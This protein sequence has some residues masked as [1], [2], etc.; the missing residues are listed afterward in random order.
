MGFVVDINCDMGESFGIYRIGNDEEVIKHITSSNIACGFHASD[1]VIMEKTVKL[2]KEHNVMAG[3]H[4]GYP[5]LIGFGRRFMDLSEKELV[6]SVI[7]Q[8]GALKGFLDLSGISLQHVK[9]HGALYNYMVNQEKLFLNIITSVRKA[10]GDVI[11][12]TLGTKRTAKLKKVCKQEGIKL[13]LEAFPDRMYT[14]EGEL[15]PRQHKEAVLKDHDRIAKRAAKMVKERGIESV[16]GQWI[17]MD[18]DTLCIHGDNMESIEAAKH[19]HGH[20]RG[21]GIEIKPLCTFFNL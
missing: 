4:P 6:N 13:A 5:D 18:I 19:I 21:E 20:V 14:D 15:L 17:E 11:F 7:Y 10:F 12:L 9:L 8:V 1:P 3:A 2:C 16:N